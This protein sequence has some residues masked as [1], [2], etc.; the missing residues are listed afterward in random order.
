MNAPQPALSGMVWVANA[1]LSSQQPG[2]KGTPH[3]T[4]DPYERIVQTLQRSSIR[5]HLSGGVF[6][7]NAYAVFDSAP[8][9]GYTSHA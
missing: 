6:P 3:N 5:S 9:H 2:C 7:C 1:L 8:L 4:S